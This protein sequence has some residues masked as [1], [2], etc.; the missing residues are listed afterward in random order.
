MNGKKAKLLRQA[1]TLPNG[2]IDAKNYSKMKRMARTILLSLSQKP[3]LVEPR[4]HKPKQP[5]G[6]TW[7]G[8]LDQARQD[9]PLIV[10]RPVRALIRKLLESNRQEDGKI[11]SLSDMQDALLRSTDGAPKYRLDQLAI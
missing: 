10:M 6:P 9:R 7:P 2:K 11:A 5:I 1:A 8:T 3:R 4:A